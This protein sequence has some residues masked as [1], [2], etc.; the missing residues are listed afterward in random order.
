MNVLILSSCTG[1]GH[2]AAA[3][4]VTKKLRE[5]GH[6]AVMLDM[7]SLAGERTARIV[8]GA[9]VKIAKNIPGFF[10]ALYKLGGKISHSGG[11]SPV[12]WA[13]SLM[14]GNL[15]LYLAEHPVD[16]IVTTHLFPAETLTYMKR[17]G[18]LAVKTV[19][20]ATDYTCIPF[21]EET[22]CDYYVIASH[23]LTGQ[24]V[25]RGI[26]RKKLLAFGIPVN[27]AF[28]RP[29]RR[30]ELRK[31]L[32]IGESQPVYLIMSGSMGFGRLQ[33]FTYEL[34]KRLE[35][36]EQIFILCGSNK[37]LRRTLKRQCSGNS[38]VHIV[39][40]TE[41]VADYMDMADVIFTKPGGLTSTEAAARRL[42]IVHTAPIPGCET[43]NME[44]FTARGM[45]VSSRRIQGQI[46]AG[47]HLMQDEGLHE[48]MRRMQEKYVDTR[49]CDRLYRFLRT[50]AADTEDSE[51]EDPAG[52]VT[53]HKGEKL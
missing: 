16:L 28:S 29:S 21:W 24:Y 36:D 3:K 23:E 18:M 14:A 26:P 13:N 34:L 52:R 10:G 25:S 17:K 44:F 40:Y 15:S 22:D 6:E 38:R 20:I 42:P 35:R 47:R 49:A 50:L 2:N 30:K 12:Y 45:S 7:F 32:G 43:E 8:G 27:D 33:I 37:K 39:G 46:E 11:H 5:K 48:H 31:R 1:E 53:P 51:R 41:H 4:A 9:Y 19:A